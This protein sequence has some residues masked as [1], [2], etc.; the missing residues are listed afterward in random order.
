MAI[1]HFKKAYRLSA[2]ILILEKL[3]KMLF[4]KGLEMI[5]QGS[6]DEVL[7]LFNKDMN[8]IEKIKTGDTA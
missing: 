8:L 6:Y 2:D 5:K 4:N 1:L 7:E 3:N